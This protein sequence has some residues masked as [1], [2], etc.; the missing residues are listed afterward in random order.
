MAKYRLS[1]SIGYSNAGQEDIID[2]KDYGYSDE[3]WEQWDDDEKE[4]ELNN[5]WQDWANNF[6]DGGWR[7]ING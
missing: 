3:E 5:I 1:L 7:K 4:V 6:I 2:T